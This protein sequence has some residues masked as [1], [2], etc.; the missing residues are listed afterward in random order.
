MKLMIFGLMLLMVG[1]VYA[2]SCQEMHVELQKY[3]HTDSLTTKTITTTDSFVMT[4][5]GNVMPSYCQDGHRY[6]CDG[7]QYVLDDCV[8]GCN[9][10]I[11]EFPIW[12]TD[13]QYVLVNGY[14]K[15]GSVAWCGDKP[16]T[17]YDAADFV[18][19]L[20]LKPSS[21][22]VFEMKDTKPM[23]PLFQGTAWTL[24]NAFL[25]MAMITLGLILMMFHRRRR[26]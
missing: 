12:T 23:P 3:T 6:V 22:W 8:K 14:N 24:Q 13:S 21:G 1:S 4:D 9:F 5:W 26:R 18:R 2:E 10:Y 15:T 16:M 25:G 11:Q 19:E 20:N 7:K 17:G